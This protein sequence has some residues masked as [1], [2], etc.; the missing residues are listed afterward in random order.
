MAIRVWLES[1]NP[2]IVVSCNDRNEE[3]VDPGPPVVHVPLNSLYADIEPELLKKYSPWLKDTNSP[4]NLDGPLMSVSLVK[5]MNG[6]LTVP[7][8]L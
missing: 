5:F 7:S 2:I 3:E 8:V 6:S 1:S 4:S